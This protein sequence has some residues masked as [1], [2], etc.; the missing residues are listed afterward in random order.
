MRKKKNASQNKV[1][2]YC[3]GPCGSRWK[4]ETLNSCYE[5]LESVLQYY[6][7]PE[8]INDIYVLGI[9]EI[10]FLIIIIGD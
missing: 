2:G 10:F 7:K 1:L 8:I 3:H 5:V 6:I 9:H 4:N